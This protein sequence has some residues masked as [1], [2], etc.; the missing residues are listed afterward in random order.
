[1]KVTHVIA[2]GPFAGAERVVLGGLDALAAC[3]HETRL[4]ALRE[5]RAPEHADALV[6][7]ARA[8]GH[9]ADCIDVRGR[10][11]REAVAALGD[12][13]GGA[14]HSHGYKATLFSRLAS[15]RRWQAWVATHHG[16]TSR[17]LRVRAYQRLLYSAYNKCDAVF[18]V[19]AVTEELLRRAGVRG[20]RLRT[21]ENFLAVPPVARVP[22]DSRE[23]IRALALG[24]LSAEKGLHVLLQ[25][26]SRAQ[27]NARIA[28]QVVGDGPERLSLVQQA[29]SLGLASSV[30]F[31]GAVVDVR[32]HLARA[33]VLVLPS[34][35]EG[36]PMTLV[37]ALCSG[38]PSLASAV[39]GVPDVLPL[40]AGKLL[41][42]GDLPAWTDA[43]GSLSAALPGYQRAAQDSALS[44]QRRFSAERWA[45]ETTDVYAQ[46]ARER[47]R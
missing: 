39:G 19:S 9:A 28:L 10:I 23:P 47:K 42:P 12:I 29:L 4:L 37:E 18:A 32:P 20:S 43:L 14:V 15:R 35:T 26:L 5:R 11:D 7:R 27:A 40:G 3:G 30:T 24:R 1:V 22:R 21:V 45:N 44:L 34:F 13:D 6:A 25:A 8:G 2:P 33:D 38:V 16:A 46:A 17:S 41:A 31:T 36:L